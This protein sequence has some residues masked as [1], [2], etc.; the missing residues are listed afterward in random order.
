MSVLETLRGRGFVAQA[1]ED[2]AVW[3]SVARGF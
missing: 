3:T 2:E 1:S